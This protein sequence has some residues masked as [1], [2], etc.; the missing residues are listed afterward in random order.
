[1]A[2]MILPFTLPFT[3]GGGPEGV[4]ASSTPPVS[5]GATVDVTVRLQALDGTWETC[6][7]DRAIKVD[8]ESLQASANEWG[9]DKAS[10]NLHRSVIAIWPDIGAFSPVEI[11]VG[12]VVV[13][14]GRTG[15]TPIRSGAEQVINVQC[16]GWQYHLDDDVYQRVYVHAKLSDWKDIRSNTACDLTKKTTSTSIANDQ[17][18]VSITLPQGAVRAAG[19][20]GGVF[21]DLGQNGAAA[22]VV[23]SW[24]HS[25]NDGSST[26]IACFANSV[27]ELSTMAASAN[28]V[29]L[30]ASPTGTAAFN[31]GAFRYV[32]L[33]LIDN[34]GAALTPGADI[35][36]KL[37]AVSVFASAVYE[38]GNA[39]VLKASTV[40]RDAVERAT[41][42]LASDLSQVQ[43]TTFAIPDFALSKA[44]TPRE[45]IEAANAYHNWI[46]KLKSGKRVAYE[47]RPTA[48]SLEI[49]AWSGA[50]IEDASANNGAEIYNRA[51]VEA[52]GA[53]GSPLSV[54][55]SSAN[56]P[57]NTFRSIT[58]PAADNPSFAVDASTW[59]SVGAGSSI[60]RETG[61]FN[62]TPASGK[63]IKTAGAVLGETFT[64]TFIAGQQYA[65]TIF[66]RP[67]VTSTYEVRLGTPTDYGR[68]L[69]GVIA[70]GAFAGVRVSWI[71]AASSSSVSLTVI[72]NG[73]GTDFVDDVSLAVVRPTLVDRRGFRR[74]KVIQ[75]SSAIT[76]VEG[77][78]LADTFL[79]A[80]MTTPFKGSAS[81][82]P[83]GVRTV[84]GGQPVHPSTLLLRTQE[85]LRLSHLT[86]PD[87][88]G[89]ARD[90]T[91]A[92]CVY[93]HKDQKTAVTLDDKRQSFDALLARLA[94]VQ[95]VGS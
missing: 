78:Q 39:S 24:A 89:I 22:R 12:G 40:A 65:A 25:N 18:S 33:F 64:G 62:T 83:G 56:Q 90:G 80:H 28:I 2:D 58:S 15:E 57:G 50:D 54:E 91:V 32:G 68:R 60:T 76:P 4:G 84:I 7:A 85:L 35:W 55:R 67:G 73:A 70:A 74:T 94:V 8:P 81:V 30:N 44:S 47:P 75:M 46:A 38:S 20:G 17:G 5:P 66:I 21:L 1:M 48:A 14:E 31:G 61:V 71:P 87:T 26:L 34:A 72:A 11:E 49:G 92:E 23:V 45:A 6:G 42:L 95:S 53:D 82:P 37:T 51:I 69:I 3:L 36:V 43:A 59:S 13:W 88:G 27:A 29:T 79:R 16:A 86:D 41:L 9:S 63:W 10:F 52:T 19:T 77:E 93:T